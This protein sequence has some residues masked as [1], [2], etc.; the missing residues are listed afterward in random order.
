MDAAGAA[1]RRTLDNTTGP[2]GRLQQLPAQV[3]IALA[4]GDL[5][6]AHAAIDEMERTVAAYKIANRVAPAFDAMLAM[7][8]GRIALAEREWVSA[9][10]SLRH[11]REQWLRVGAPFEVAQARLHLGLAYRRKGDE[12]GATTELEAALSAFERLGARLDEERARELLGRLRT[13]RTFLFTDIVGSTQLLETLGDDKWRKLLGRHDALVRQA[14]V[15]AGGEVIKQTGDGFFAAFEHPKAAIQAAVA[16]Q[17]ALDGEIVAPDVRI[18]LHTGGAFHTNADAADYGG[19]GVH[20]A[21]RI[22][23]AAGA[24]EILASQQTLEAVQSAFP[25]YE[26]RALELKGIAQSVSVVSV[27]WR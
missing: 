17:R 9:E 22:G 7:A 16:V 27:D 10:R 4:A 24:G 11:A 15:D 3:E 2:L 8:G 5:R 12:D 20:V 21:A 1:I 13:R 14:I 23:A 6:T 26:P 25:V 19:Q 18:G